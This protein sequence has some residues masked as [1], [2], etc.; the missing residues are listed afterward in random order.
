MADRK[1]AKKSIKLAYLRAFFAH[2]FFSRAYF[3][4]H[5][6]LKHIYRLI[7]FHCSYFQSCKMTDSIKKC[8]NVCQKLKNHLISTHKSKNSARQM[9]FI[10]SA[11]LFL[12]STQNSGLKKAK[13]FLVKSLHFCQEAFIRLIYVI[14]VE[15]SVKNDKKINR[16]NPIEIFKVKNLKIQTIWGLINEKTRAHQTY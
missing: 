11:I 3:C 13:T 10:V 16:A 1:I 2:N 4:V 7:S 15:K 8:V 14:F 12:K 9:H 5:F 6:F